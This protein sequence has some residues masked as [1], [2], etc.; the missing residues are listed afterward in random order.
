LREKAENGK[1]KAEEEVED[2]K[3]CA[4]VPRVVEWLRR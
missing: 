3:G 2:I 1:L 4:H